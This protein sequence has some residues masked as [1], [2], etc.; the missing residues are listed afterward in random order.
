MENNT[1]SLSEHS[2]FHDAFFAMLKAM[3][4][5][6]AALGVHMFMHGYELGR[7]AAKA[8]SKRNE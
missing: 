4:P 7:A 6:S 1:R 5:E 3:L 2:L 8:E